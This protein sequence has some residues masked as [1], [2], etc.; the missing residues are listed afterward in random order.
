MSPTT[1]V[2]F[3]S[4]FAGQLPASAGSSPATAAST[5]DT[6]GSIDTD[7]NGRVSLLEIQ[8]FARK[9]GIASQE[10]RGD[11]QELDSN[12]DGEL[13]AQEMSGLLS[14]SSSVSATANA[15][16]ATAA[17][18]EPATTPNA[19]LVAT[20]KAEP[21]V[22]AKAAGARSAVAE[23][24]PSLEALELDARRQSG[25]IVAEGLARRAQVM[26]KQ[27][28]K[29]QK[30]SE[31]YE[32][33]AQALRGAARGAA[34]KMGAETRSASERAVNAAAKH[35]L[36]KAQRLKTQSEELERDAHQH[37]ERAKQALRQASQA[38][39]GLTTVSKH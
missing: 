27:G 9:S 16:P 36:V 5:K 26:M 7:G 6:L 4:I 34:K 10:I 20:A 13:D 28:E 30:E 22:P 23:T 19:E 32:A 31:S 35:G 12:G 14:P 2:V 18:A 38:Q 33:K 24:V 29:D 15:E 17:R 37:H 21:T 39:D 1:I 11:F 8:E 25:G 3:V